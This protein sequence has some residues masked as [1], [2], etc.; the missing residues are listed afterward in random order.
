[1]YIYLVSTKAYSF[2]FISLSAFRP[3]FRLY[4]KQSYSTEEED[5]GKTKISSQFLII[6]NE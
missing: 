6:E 1:M 5:V 2:W 3:L 4:N